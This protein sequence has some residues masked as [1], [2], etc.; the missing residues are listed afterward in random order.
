MTNRQKIFYFTCLQYFIVVASYER[1]YH[2]IAISWTMTTRIKARGAVWMAGLF[3]ECHHKRCSQKFAVVYCLTMAF[4]F[5]AALYV[6][7]PSTIR[8]LDRDHPSHIK[9]RSLASI[10]I[11]IGAISSYPLLF[12]SLD[13]PQTFWIV[14]VLFWPRHI[15]GV[16]IHTT[17]LYSGAIVASLLR[18]YEQ[19]KRRKT[20]TSYP[21]DVFR[22]LLYPSFASAVNPR[23]EGERWRNIR[24]FV[25]APLTEEL[26]FRGCM[27]P[28]LLASGMSPLR[29]SVVA[30]LFFG[31]AHLHHAATRLLKG[32]RI[33]PVLAMTLFQFVYTSLFGSYAAY[34]FIRT[35]S[36]AACYDQ[37]CVLQLDG[38]S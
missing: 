5:V 16:L 13:G 3:D 20:K 11:C 26:L 1:V 35:G 14:N 25:M 8:K 9:W 37:P 22:Q 17:I 18:V 15:H 34:A 19:R 6:L 10:I 12:C 29:V 24:N 30:P 33:R 23:S 38:T 2:T 32:E 7:V 21:Q 27:V 36:V 28:A 31:V 4:L